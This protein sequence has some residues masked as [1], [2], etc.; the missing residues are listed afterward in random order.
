MIKKYLLAG[1]FLVLVNIGY[2]SP[3]AIK[4]G[5][6]YTVIEKSAVARTR[7]VL[8]REFFSFTCVHC[9]EL[10]PL[11]EKYVAANK[12]KVNLEKIHVVWNDD[13]V[14]KN[15]AKLSATLE[16][17][18]LTRLYTPA[19]NAIFSQQNLANP[20]ILTNF[21]QQNKLT[22]S[23]INN[24]FSVYNSFAIDAAINKYKEMT[25]NLLYNI[26]ATPTIIVN[27]QY[28]VSPAQPSRLIEVVNALVNKT[29]S[30]K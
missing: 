14:L 25:L 19:F 22:K 10:D 9:K 20:D 27:E 13:I 23:Q 21:L 7:P 17:M 5:V 18:K 15:L 28:I 3:I 16:A 29:I 24:F 1:F 8:V 30:G 2:T 26:I 6:D 4:E 11:M 12:N